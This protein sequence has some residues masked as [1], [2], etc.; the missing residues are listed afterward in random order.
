MKRVTRAA[1]EPLDAREEAFFR[2]LAR[3][4]VIVPRAFDTDLIRE[5]GMSRTEY[6]TLMHLSEAPGRSLRMS[7]IAAAADLSLSGITRIVQRL[8]AQGW[9]RREK[10]TCDGRGWNA[11]LTDAGFTRLREAW[12]THLASARRHVMDHLTDIDLR[13]ITSAMENFAASECATD[14]SSSPRPS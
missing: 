9:V 3:V 12:P 5:Q 13:A 7:D 8:E 1:V 2:A 6:S 11:V 4:M 10:S 14:R